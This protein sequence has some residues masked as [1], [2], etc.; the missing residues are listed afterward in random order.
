MVQAPFEVPELVRVLKGVDPT[1]LLVPTRLLRRVIKQD[2]QIG[3]IGLFVPHRKSYVISGEA[4]LRI[5]DRAELGLA[6][7]DNLPANV[8]LLVR[9]EP[10]RLARLTREQV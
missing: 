1:A 4:L 8:M 2:R 7:S 10:D 5:A 9:P 6:E 3:G